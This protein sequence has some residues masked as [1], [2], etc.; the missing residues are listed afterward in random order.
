MRI[1]CDLSQSCPEIRAEGGVNKPWSIK[2]RTSFFGGALGFCFAL[3][4][5]L[6][7]ACGCCCFFFLSADDVVVGAAV[8]VVV[9]AD[10][11][12]IWGAIS[13]ILFGLRVVKCL[14]PILMKTNWCVAA[15]VLLLQNGLA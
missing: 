9:V 5:A 1:W 7:L 15:V 4:L 8:T 10:S 3:A 12:E 13:L 2:I 11:G 14:A 6:A